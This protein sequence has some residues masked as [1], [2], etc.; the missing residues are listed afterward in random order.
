[1]AIRKPVRETN[2]GSKY[3]YEPFEGYDLYFRVPEIGKYS[4]RILRCTYT[5]LEYGDPQETDGSDDFSMPGGIG[6]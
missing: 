6:I 1:M 2:L 5:L 3:Y 4:Y